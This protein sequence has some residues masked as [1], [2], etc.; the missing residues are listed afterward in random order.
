M[1]EIEKPQIAAVESDDT[2][3]RFV[4][5]PLERGY[6]ITLGNSLRR[7][8]LSSLPGA[9]VTSVRIDGVLHEFSTI[10]GVV[11]DT[12]DIVLN[13]KQLLLKVHTDE[14]VTLRLDAKGE[15]PVSAGGIEPNADVEILN[16]ELEIDHLD[17]DGALTVAVP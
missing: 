5:E 11:E 13:V 2:Y 9:A 8:L 14:P 3:G 10:P 15:G 16:P 4:V 1:L 12:T 17:T 6:G 7:I